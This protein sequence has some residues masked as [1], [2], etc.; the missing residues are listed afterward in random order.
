MRQEVIKELELITDE[1]KRVL[2]GEKQQVVWDI[3]ST[4]DRFEGERIEMEA[5]DILFL[6]KEAKHSIEEAGIHDIGLNFMALPEFFDIPLGML[7]KDNILADFLVSVL[8][9]T[10]TDSKYLYFKLG[11]EPIVDNLIERETA[12]S[13]RFTRRDSGFSLL[14]K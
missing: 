7:N 3:Y 12:I 6:N 5:G 11:H 4:K 9:N 8:R 13:N 2:S 10:D 1:E 14:Y